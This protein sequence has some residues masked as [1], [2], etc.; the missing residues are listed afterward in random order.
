[1]KLRVPYNAGNLLTGC[2]KVSFSRRSLQHAVS[3]AHKNFL[4]KNSVVSFL[5]ERL[6]L[7]C[8][9]YSVGQVTPAV[10]VYKFQCT[11]NIRYQWSARPRAD[12]IFAA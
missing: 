6:N 5:Y 4:L 3:I 11:A 8:A 1:M 9:E 2:E 10:P 12:D 7:S